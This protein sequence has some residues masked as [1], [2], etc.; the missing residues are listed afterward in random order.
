MA[1]VYM[2]SLRWIGTAQ[3]NELID[4]TLGQ[5]GDWMRWNGWTWFVAT[6]RSVSEV[7]ASVMANLKSEDSL[8]VLEI[9]RASALE[10]WAP[11]WVWEWFRSRLEGHFRT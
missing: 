9:D 11:P 10:G 6:N 3:N 7:R 5:I 4:K 2:V 8:L 1:K